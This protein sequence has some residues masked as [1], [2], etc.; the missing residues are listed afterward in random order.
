MFWSVNNVKGQTPTFQEH[1]FSVSNISKATGVLN[2][3]SYS[4]LDLT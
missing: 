4:F 2:I 3:V 1:A